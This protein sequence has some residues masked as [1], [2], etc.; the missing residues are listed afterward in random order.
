MIKTP[1]PIPAHGTDGTRPAEGAA[2][3]VLVIGA[4]I[5]G[6]S[7]ARQLAS[8][9]IAVTVIEKNKPASGAS[10]NPVAVVRPEP[11][12]AA[13][14]IAEFSAAGVVWLKNWLVLHGSRVPHEFCGALRITRDRRR[15]DKLAAHALTVPDDWLREVDVQ[16]ARALCGQT[17]AAD[18]FFLP[19]AGWVQTSSLVEA[20]L[21]HP[22][23]TLRTGLGATQLAPLPA[24][25]WQLDLSDGGQIRATRLV[26]A[27]AYGELSPVTLA[28]D[29]ARGQLSL[30]PARAGRD[31]HTIVCRDGYITPA[32]NGM[33]TIGATIQYED[34]DGSAR[35]T[36][37]AENF[38]RLQRL[39]PGFAQTAAELQSGRVSWRAT[40]QDRL[41]LVGK[42]AAD[43]YASV[44]HGSRGIACGPLCAEFL[45]ALMM[46]EPLPLGVE[47]IARLDPM[48]FGP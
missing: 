27:N 10:G 40:T 29:R 32:V 24:G 45:V 20:M 26:L 1:A 41:P 18:A 13:N 21:D 3:S 19:Q 30:L 6:A 22:L 31:L 12:G 9:G 14:P 23:I 42:L 16:Q 37:D 44:G 43:L 48:R 35:Q 25:G 7:V 15:H 34:E 4:G 17:I 38:E 11:G 46:N 39:V 5:A 8:R 36:D 28:L 2:T 47:W 33:H